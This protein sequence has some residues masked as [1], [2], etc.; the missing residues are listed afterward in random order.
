MN[1]EFVLSSLWIVL[2]IISLIGVI[3]NWRLAN[4]FSDLLRSEHP[5][6]WNRI[7]SGSVSS[8]GVSTQFNFLKFIQD[9]KYESLGDEVIT[10]HGN[11]LRA[12]TN[13]YY[14]LIVLFFLVTG[15][16]LY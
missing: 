11:K 5:D 10:S 15:Y 2:F 12:F 8:G 16:I 6:T 9:R 4:K 14:A 3:I 1:L 13:V 7:Q